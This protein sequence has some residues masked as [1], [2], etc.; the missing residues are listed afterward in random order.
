MKKRTLIALFL[1]P[2]LAIGCDSLFDKG[3]VEKTYDG[4]NQLAFGVLEENNNLGCSNMA[5]TVELQLLS[6]NGV[7][8]SDMSVA[9][10]AAG[11]S[12]ARATTDYSFATPSPVT[13]AAGEARTDININFVVTTM[14]EAAVAA[15][16]FDSSRAFG[17]YTGV[18]ANGG[19]GNGATYNVTVPEFGEVTE[20]DSVSAADPLRTAGTYNNVA[21]N[22]GNGSE[23]LFDVVIDANGAATVTI[24]SDSTGGGTRYVVEDVLTLPALGNW[25]TGSDVNVTVTDVTGTAAPS[26]AVVAGGIDYQCSDTFTIPDS[27]LGNGGAPALPFSVGDLTGSF[28]ADEVL[29]LLELDGAAGVKVAANQDSTRIFM[30]K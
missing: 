24:V 21:A 23:A 2:V 7:A 17:T 12:T 25:N 1:I 6:K 13:I 27:D 18:S 8:S 30:A 5:T 26:V 3:D 28:A 29:L 15:T 22:G 11:G 16:A 14:D 9:F 4:P 20:V 19:S 10:G